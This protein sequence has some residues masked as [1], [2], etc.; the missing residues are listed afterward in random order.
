MGPQ[1]LKNLDRAD[2]ASLKGVSPPSDQ[3]LLDHARENFRSDRNRW[4]WSGFR[5]AHR[6]RRWRWDEYRSAASREP[7]LFLDSTLPKE[8]QI[9]YISEDKIVEFLRQVKGE[10]DAELSG[11]RLVLSFS[12]D[13]SP[14]YTPSTGS[15][16]L[17][18]L[19]DIFKVQWLQ[20]HYP[21]QISTSLLRDETSLEN[22]R[23]EL[24]MPRSNCEGRA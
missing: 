21:A 18:G 2:L 16:T 11:G 1:S 3:S 6:I 5:D 15:E 10:D 8:Q 13:M 23:G 24:F 17:L 14:P 7:P 9:G 12:K 22:T 20:D 19:S 4:S